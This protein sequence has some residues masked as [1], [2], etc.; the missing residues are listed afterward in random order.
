MTQ[1]PI[2]LLALLALSAC[3]S[4]PPKK[5]DVL[6]A[7]APPQT[8]PQR[9]VTNFS[10]ALRCMDKLYISYGVRDVSVVLEDLSDSTRKVSAGTRDMM[11]SALSDQTR[12]SR[13]IEVSAFGQD[14][15]NAVAFLANAQKRTAFAV[16]PQ[17]NL[18]GSISQLDEGVLKRQADGGVSLGNLLGA[19]A[20]TSR[21]FNVL[22]LDVA[23]ADTTRLTLI[24]GVVSKNLT[25][26]VKEGDALDAQATFS[27]IGINFSTSFQRTDGT[28][29]ALRNMVELSSVEL[30]GR[31]LKLPYWQCLGADARNP[32]VREEIEDWFVGMERGGE[33]TAYFQTQLRNRGFYDGPADGNVTPA[34]RQAVSSYRAALGM[35][36]TPAVDLA[37]FTVFLEGPFPNPPAVAARDVLPAAQ[38]PAA[39]IALALDAVEQGAGEGLGFSVSSSAPAYVYCYARTAGGKLQRI[40][41]NRFVS[42]P[43]IEPG[44]PLLLPGRQGFKLIPGESGTVPVACFA[45][46]REIYN[47]IPAALRWGD[48]QDLNKVR[49]FSDV[50]SMLEAVARE[51]VAVASRQLG[52]AAAK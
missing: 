45:A 11:M 49:E 52:R 39:R 43:R 25:T 8:L 36:D 46:P 40:F 30:F 2:W 50:Q 24:P 12:R 41:P 32:E 26:I 3:T 27:K 42:D 7:V 14:A 44:Q 6:A 5:D 22:G 19:G 31:L 33:L 35:G 23:L 13:A 38:A 34:L 4:L 10:D 51:P 29:Q 15:N 37:F 48:F 1:K 16:V 21:Q 28:A 18:R 9:N 20:S 47:D 17:F